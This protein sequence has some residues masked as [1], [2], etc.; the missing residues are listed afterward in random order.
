MAKQ[1]WQYA[2]WPDGTSGSNP[3]LT[4]QNPDAVVDWPSGTAPKPCTVFRTAWLNQFIGWARYVSTESMS[5][6]SQGH[7]VQSAS[8]WNENLRPALNHNEDGYLCKTYSNSD[9]APNGQFVPIPLTPSYAKIQSGQIIHPGAQ[10][11]KLIEFLCT[12]RAEIDKICAVEYTRAGD[13]Y[14]D[15]WQYI[16][17]SWDGSETV[18]PGYTINPIWLYC[19]KQEV[20]GVEGIY[21]NNMYLY[22]VRVLTQMRGYRLAVVSMKQERPDWDQGSPDG[23]APDE[24]P[25]PTNKMIC[26]A[27]KDIAPNASA[28]NWIC[29]AGRVTG[30]SSLP[31]EVDDGVWYRTP[32]LWSLIMDS[33]PQP[34]RR[35]WPQ[36][37]S[38]Y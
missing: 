29:N 36:G 13:P 23:D 35:G 8:F 15:E 3:N 16:E 25:M 4:G 37:A 22:T 38:S 27:I 6:I 17:R 2:N 14:S 21:F 11:D 32:L 5:A 30:I 12:A 9:I 1:W 7:N 20:D 18:R 33:L 26:H 19:W 28:G 34:Y 31:S 24:F 10:N